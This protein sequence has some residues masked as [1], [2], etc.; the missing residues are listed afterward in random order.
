LR[1]V[2]ERAIILWPA[3][4]IEPEAFPEQISHQGAG[5][6]VLGGNY[7]LELIEKEQ[8]LRVLARTST[9]EEA[10]YILGIDASTLWRKR[11]K[12]QEEG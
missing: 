3:Q 2:L 4:V 11:K 10:A 5:A 9:L 7:S 6:P 1:N 8:I 12:Y